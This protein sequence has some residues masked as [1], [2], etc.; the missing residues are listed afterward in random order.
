MGIVALILAVVAVLLAL[1]ALLVAFIAF[2]VA[3]RKIR[4]DG[5]ASPGDTS[6]PAKVARVWAAY[7]SRSVH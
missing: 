2:A 4:V 6:L 3:V 5:A 1:A 7:G